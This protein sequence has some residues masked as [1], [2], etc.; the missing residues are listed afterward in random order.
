MAYEVK[1]MTGSIFTNQGKEKENQP[2]F[3]GSFRIKGVDY[4]VAGWKKT[5][6]TGLEYTSYKIEDKQ[7]RTPF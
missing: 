5:A 7:D 4:S 1:D 6:K 3:T 2:D